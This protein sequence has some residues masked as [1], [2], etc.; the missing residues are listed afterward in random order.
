MEK[1][2][3]KKWYLMFLLLLSLTI[4]VACNN[5]EN[6][7]EMVEVTDFVDDVVMVPKNP[8]KIA[9]IAR[10]AADMLVAFGL[11]IG[12]ASCRERV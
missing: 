12:R 4:L 2:M 9:V 11:E 7:I 5:T 3:R 8:K 10:S 6:E 1:D